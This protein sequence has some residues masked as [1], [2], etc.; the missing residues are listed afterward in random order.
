MLTNDNGDL[1]VESA[2]R[3]L[4]LHAVQVSLEVQGAEQVLA[5]AD[6]VGCERKECE[7]VE[8]EDAD[9][10]V[11]NTKTP[12]TTTTTTEG[13]SCCKADSAFGVTVHVYA[14]HYCDLCFWHVACQC[15]PMDSLT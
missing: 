1:R 4:R 8:T 2:R 15:R 9:D 10:C 3:Q 11:L 14:D 5:L 6:Q 12:T 7:W 13:P